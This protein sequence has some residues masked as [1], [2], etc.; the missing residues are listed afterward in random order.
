M[1]DSAYDHYAFQI[2]EM[3]HHYGSHVHL[4]ADPVL[5][6]MLGRLCQPQVVQPEVTNL[7]RD[8]YETLVRVVMANEL[9]RRGMQIKTRMFE[10]TPAGVWSGSVLDPDTR[11]VT[12]NI[13]RAGMQPSQ[14]AFEALTRLLNPNLVRQDHLYMSRVTD[15]SDA[16]VGVKMAGDKIGGSVTNAIVLFPDPMGATGSSIVQSG[17]IYKNLVG[18]K[19]KKMVAMHL[20]VTPEYLRRVLTEHPEMII[21]AVRLDRGL[22][23]PDI[24]ASELGEHWDQECGLNERQYIVP[25]AGGLGEI[26]NNS[27]V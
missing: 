23:K 13:A 17:T 12:V 8:I 2:P 22:S 3:R 19:P 6:T 9:P 24:L 21:Y 16:V 7:I 14:V 26:L 4:L 5:L 11:V 27:Y 25:G 1:Y 10:S 20:V 15:A 18:G